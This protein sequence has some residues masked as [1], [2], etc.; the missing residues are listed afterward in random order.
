MSW[1]IGTHLQQPRPDSA[2]VT[3][4]KP[5]GSRAFPDITGNVPDLEAVHTQNDQLKAKCTEM[6]REL[7]LRRTR[8]GV[9]RA[10]YHKRQEILNYRNRLNTMLG[11]DIAEEFDMANVQPASQPEIMEMS[12]VLNSTLA[13]VF[14]DPQ[15]R[16]WYNLFTYLD[17]DRTGEKPC[18]H[19]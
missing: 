1:K 2:P 10:E 8:F 18:N 4:R 13:R 16:S 15:R 11:G 5:G 6:K 7:Y 17:K 9:S 3:S 12:R 19:L 14:A